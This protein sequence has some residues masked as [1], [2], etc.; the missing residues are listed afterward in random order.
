MTLS[1]FAIVH[2]IRLGIGNVVEVWFYNEDR[3]SNIVDIGKTAL[4]NCLE[5]IELLIFLLATTL[6]LA[7]ML[8]VSSLKMH[9]S[10]VHTPITEREFL[11]QKH[12]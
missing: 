1:R 2:R 7:V 10:H 4:V 11:W 6:V 9:F 3:Y 8:Q 5:L 12:Y